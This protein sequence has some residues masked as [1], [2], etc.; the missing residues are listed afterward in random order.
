MGDSFIKRL[1]HGGPEYQKR[2][3]AEKQAKAE[4][5]EVEMKSYKEGLKIG[6]RRK[7]RERGIAKGQGKSGLGGFLQGAGRSM[8]AFESGAGGLI[9][10]V[11]LGGIGQG[12]N[13]DFGG[14]GGF[15]GTEPR[16]HR[17]RPR[18]RNKSRRR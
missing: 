5:Y 1:I 18:K 15:G 11:D 3:E 13:A 2:K 8:Q 4:A 6:A 7:G 16:Q 10:D 14:L 9:G 17:Q 12:L